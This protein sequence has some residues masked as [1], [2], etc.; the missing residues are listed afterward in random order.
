ML[1]RLGRARVR[2]VVTIAVVT[3][4]V[5]S[6]DGAAVVVVGG[7]P[8]G[9]SGTRRGVSVVESSTSAVS[10]RTMKSCASWWS[11]MAWPHY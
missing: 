1:E 9:G 7:K 2:A 6:G 5:S 8:S 4:V 3:A 11:V 10:G